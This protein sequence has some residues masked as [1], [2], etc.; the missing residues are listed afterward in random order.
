MY[1]STT[2]DPRIPSQRRMWHYE[3]GNPLSVAQL[4]SLGSLDSRTAALLWLLVERHASLIV[5]APT[6]PSPGIGKPTPRN[7]LLGFL[8]AGTSLVYTAGMYEDFE[9]KDQ[10]APET[11]CVLCNEVS[12]HLPIYMWGRVARRFLRLP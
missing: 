2:F 10:V 3:S 8:P 9:F 12:D 5:S 11:T 7:A 1:W 4:V 6:H